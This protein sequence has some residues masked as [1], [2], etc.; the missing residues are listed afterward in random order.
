MNQQKMALKSCGN[1]W[2]IIRKCICSSYFHQA[3]RLKGIGEYVNMR[4]GMPC[5][6]H[7]TSALF[8]MGYTPDYIVYHELVM[9]SK[10]YMQCFT[11]V[12]GYWLAELGPMFYTVKESTKTRLEIDTIESP[13]AQW[14]EHPTRSRR[15]VGSSPI[16][17]SDFFLLH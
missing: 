17:G 12:E 5:H 16:W 6:L 7:P 14:L 13:V 2:D 15:V 4:T 9:T 1:G 11:A 3:V 10:E 8:D